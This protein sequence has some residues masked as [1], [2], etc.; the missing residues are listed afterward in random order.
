MATLRHVRLLSLTSKLMLRNSLNLNAT[1]TESFSRRCLHVA[2]RRHPLSS[3]V[4]NTTQ[5]YKFDLFKRSQAQLWSVCG[6]QRYNSTETT[7]SKPEFELEQVNFLP[8]PPNLPSYIDVSEIPLNALGEPTLQSLG[9]GS[10]WPAGLYQQALELLH[11][12]GLTWLGAIAVV[13]VAIRFAM[14]PL[15]VMVQRNAAKTQNA[16]PKLSAINDRVFRAQKTGNRLELMK[17]NQELRDTMKAEDVHPL[18][19][20]AVLFAQA[21]IFMTVFT[22]LRGMTNVPVESLKSGGLGWVTD[23]TVPDP[24]FILPILT[25]STLFLTVELGTDTGMKLDDTNKKIKQVVRVLP[26]VTL[27]IIAK[28]PAALCFY[29]F[30]SNMYSLFMVL[31]FKLNAVQRFFKIPE[32]I[33]H[34][35]KFQ[36]P[37]DEPASKRGILET[38]REGV[39]I[40][41]KV[42]EYESRKKVGAITFQDSQT[43]RKGMPASTSSRKGI[44]T[45]TKSETR[46]KIQNE[47][48]EERKTDS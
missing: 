10:N 4:S 12:E 42:L 28:F 3:S 44:S 11:V 46:T 34:E 23:L 25:A 17:C 47:E 15:N 20:F 38:F 8:E 45:S 33:M 30:I 48:K 5:N 6:V 37:G 40:S 1:F 2:S 39:K 13:T 43:N 31:F 9:I 32:R 14:L 24:L 35:P 26:L 36:Q 29:W 18:K 19:N 21:P 16:A 41:E 7:T 27:V 22:G